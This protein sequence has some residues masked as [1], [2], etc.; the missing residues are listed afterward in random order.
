MPALLSSSRSREDAN[1]RMQVYQKVFSNYVEFMD[2]IKTFSGVSE[3]PILTNQMFNA[4]ISSYVQ[5]FAGFLGIERSLDQPVALLGFLDVLGVT[6][7]RT[8]MP[9]I[10][11]EDFSNIGSKIVSSTAQATGTTEYSI[12]LGKK[13]IPRS[14]KVTLIKTGIANVTLTDD[15]N[16]N[17]IASPGILAA[18]VDGDPGIN[19]STG[20]VTITTG[21][22]YTPIT[23]A[24]NTISITAAE[25][26]AGVPETGGVGYYANRF[27][28]GFNTVTIDTAPDMLIGESNIIA[29]AQMKKSLGINPSDFLTSKLIELYTKVINKEL[30]SIINDGYT[31]NTTPIVLLKATTGYLDWRSA[32][33]KFSAGMI[34]VDGAL[35]AKSVKG[36][37]ATSY[38]VSS[39]IAD[40][41]RKTKNIG[42]FVDNTASNYVNDLVGFYDGVPVLRHTDITSGYGYAIHKTF[43]G[44]LAPLMRGIFLPLT[45]TPAVGN[46][47]NP[48]QVANGVFYQ[49]GA[50][51]IAQELV[52]KFSVTQD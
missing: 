31:G 39:T 45:N 25:D 37:R 10:G 20:T 41:F 32:I 14:V 16:G 3:T 36:I 11:A 1:Q 44:Q 51:S 46:Y 22:G 15:G 42:K 35:A 52:V 40:L 27:K 49:E 43:D 7:G 8:V 48:T 30:V 12:L 4:T 21:A 28:T 5:S 38:V 2:S 6:D 18:N 29:M 26:S 50:Q 19:Y 17:L 13:L 24:T 34:D 47:N 9:N 23:G 33:D